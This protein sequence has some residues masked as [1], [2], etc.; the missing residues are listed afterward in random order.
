[1]SSSRT[2]PVPA[3]PELNLVDY[4]YLFRRRRWTL[5]SVFLLVTAVGLALTAISRPV[6]QAQA[7]VVVAPA[8]P[9]TNALATP[10]PDSLATQV[11]TLRSRQFLADAYRLAD[12]QPTPGLAP[13]VKIEPVEN[14]SSILITVDGGDPETITRLANTIVDLHVKRTGEF[15]MRDV[16]RAL[17]YMQREERRARG[18]YDNAQA[19]L[20]GF[21]TEHGEREDSIFQDTRAREYAALTARSRVAESNIV[22]ARA[23]L[24]DLRARLDA[25]P[26]FRTEPVSRPNPRAETLQAR[27]DDLQAERT[28]LL[29]NYKPASPQVQSLDQQIA[30]LQKQLDAE[31]KEQVTQNQIQNPVRSTLEASV[32]RLESSLRGYEAERQLALSDVG[33]VKPPTE[34]AKGPVEAERARLLHERD[35]TEATHA[36]LTQRRNELEMRLFAGTQAARPLQTADVPTDPIS[37][38]PAANVALTLM[39]AV[40]LAFGTA[41]LQDYF[42]DRINTREDV[43]RVSDLPALGHVPALGRGQSQLMVELPSNSR[44]AESYR[45]IRTSI[46]LASLENPLRRLLVTSP[47]GREGR[48]LTAVNLATAMAI[49]GK[50]VV[51]VDADLRLPSV[52]K[53]LNLKNDRGVLQVVAG[54][55]KLDEALQPTDL[56]NLLVLCAGGESATAAEILGSS[57]FEALLEQLEYEADIVILDCPPVLPV[58]DALVLARRMDGVVLVVRAGQTRQVT[59]KRAVELLTRARARILGVVYNRMQYDTVQDVYQEADQYYQ[60]RGGRGDGGSGRAT[61]IPLPQT[62]TA[63]PAR[64]AAAE[65]GVRYQRNEP[66]ENP[67]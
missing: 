66:E 59:I 21:L 49:D 15:A 60:D 67:A 25:E 11:R 13:T 52:H 63:K 41:L 37:R 31:P 38:S 14:T 50:R 62:T 20:I 26:A 33:A 8:P 17:E 27:M 36:L 43:E 1:M 22:A 10:Q 54:Q 61:I 40:S 42:D 30:T 23:E 51:L 28:T 45:A 34:E 12:V 56:H 46:C 4:R 48:T 6:Y 29:Q 5:I 58:T 32:A 16:G 35:T 55:R 64:V 44:A 47:T 57:A 65:G 7:E 53:S 9:P 19:R 18:E 39:L 3:P 2:E 24:T